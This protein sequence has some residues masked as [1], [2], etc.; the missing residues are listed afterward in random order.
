MAVHTANGAGQ[1]Q[2]PLSFVSVSF[3]AVHCESQ[4]TSLFATPAACHAGKS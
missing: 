3:A 4:G 2:P 1:Q